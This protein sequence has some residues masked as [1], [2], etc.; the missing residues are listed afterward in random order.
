MTISIEQSSGNVFEDLGLDDSGG[1]IK[2]AE[3]LRQIKKMIW[4]LRLPDEKVEQLVG[5]SRLEFSRFNSGIVDGFSIEQ[6]D[7]ILTTL[8][9]I[10]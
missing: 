4:L 7:R 8:R 10:L 1:L 9:G 6:L 3:K 2:K 5:L